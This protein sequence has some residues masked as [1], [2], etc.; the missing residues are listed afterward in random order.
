VLLMVLGALA[1]QCDRAG[2]G[3]EFGPFQITDFGAAA[4]G[5]EE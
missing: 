5:E 3:V 2:L 1:R 4:A